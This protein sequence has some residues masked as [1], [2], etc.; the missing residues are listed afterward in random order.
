MSATAENFEM[1]LEREGGRRQWPSKSVSPS[2]VPRHLAIRRNG[3]TPVVVAAS[4]RGRPHVLAPNNQQRGTWTTD[5]HHAASIPPTALPLSRNAI[6]AGPLSIT[7]H[8][9]FLPFHP[10]PA[11]V[12]SGR[13]LLF[14]LH[15]LKDRSCSS[16]SCFAS[17]MSPA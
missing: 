5:G 1:R 10:D 3:D 7:I 6:K 13:F 16:R 11:R 12:G 15:S 2:S 8:P 14:A 9:A 17:A 4:L